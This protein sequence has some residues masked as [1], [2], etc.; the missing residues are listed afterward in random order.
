MHFLCLCSN[1]MIVA[2]GCLPVLQW[3]TPVRT[4]VHCTSDGY[5]SWW[6]NSAIE[7]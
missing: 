4:E 1:M 6:W 3:V 5:K 2:M 7:S